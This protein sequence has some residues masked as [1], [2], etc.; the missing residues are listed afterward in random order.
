[1]KIILTAMLF[2]VLKLIVDDKTMCQI[3]DAI[4][5]FMIFTY[6]LSTFSPFTEEIMNIL[7]G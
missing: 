4:G 6:L 3:I 1:M 2:Q 5:C 7:G